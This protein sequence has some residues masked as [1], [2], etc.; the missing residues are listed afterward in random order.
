MVDDQDKKFS[1]NVHVS[2]PMSQTKRLLSE[3]VWCVMLIQD[4]Q[5]FGRPA[6]MDLL[7]VMIVN[8]REAE[9]HLYSKYYQDHESQ[10]A[11]LEWAG[12]R[13]M[14]G[15]YMPKL[16]PFQRHPPGPQT[17]QVS[18]H[19]SLK[20]QGSMLIAEGLCICHNFMRAVFHAMALHRMCR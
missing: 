5:A 8:C 10:N 18:N 1:S 4:H 11:F 6:Q 3:Q 12:K 14:P 15:L 13:Y 7:I 19:C 16:Q 17:S 20:A 2:E 9:V